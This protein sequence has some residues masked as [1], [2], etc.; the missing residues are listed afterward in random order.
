LAPKFTFH[1]PRCDLDFMKTGW[2]IG[3]RAGFDWIPHWA[4]YYVKCPNCNERHWYKL[5]QLVLS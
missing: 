3:P 5:V 1:C 4:W 2:I